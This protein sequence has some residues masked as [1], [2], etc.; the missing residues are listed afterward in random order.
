MVAEVFAGLG[1][2]KSAFDIARG[3]KDMDDAA[4]RNAAVIDLQQTILTAQQAQAALLEEMDRLKKE[5]AELKEWEVGKNDYQL[6]KLGNETFVYTMKL[7]NSGD[8]A[9]HLCPNCFT[10]RKKSSLQKSVTHVGRWTVYTCNRCGLE[11]FPDGG[12]RSPNA[13]KR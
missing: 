5:N 8:P 3:I 1:A 11:I 10:D 2:L 4:K 12:G 6:I 9:H 13:S 7:S